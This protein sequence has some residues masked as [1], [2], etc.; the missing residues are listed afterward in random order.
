ME[1]KKLI[2]RYRLPSFLLAAM[3]LAVI[4]VLVSMHMY[5]VSGAAQ[6]DLSR[7]EY[8]AV[9]SQITTESKVGE[10]FGTQS[11]VTGDRQTGFLT[12]YKEH[13]NKVLEANVFSNDVLSDEQ[14][15]IK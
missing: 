8:A 11:A 13:A 4:M 7:P 9:R 10:A 3:F 5:Y 12:K 15:G 2:L 1:I 6:L 14:L